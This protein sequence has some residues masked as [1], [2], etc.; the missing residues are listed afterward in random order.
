M[1]VEKVN[2]AWDNVLGVPS[3]DGPAK[4]EVSLCFKKRKIIVLSIFRSSELYG[5]EKMSLLR[6]LFFKMVRE[7]SERG[8]C[9][10]D[11][12]DRAETKTNKALSAI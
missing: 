10:R 7:R 3:D 6:V 4:K 8:S 9:R 1:L 2:R 11:R 5:G 12:S